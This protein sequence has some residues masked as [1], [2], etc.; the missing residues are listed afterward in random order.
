[1]YRVFLAIGGLAGMLGLVAGTVEAHVLRGRLPVERLAAFE[2][3]VRY[4]MYHALAL[5]A[6][7]WLCG[8][9]GG[10]LPVLAGGLFTVGMVFFSGSLYLRAL[11][12]QPQFGRLAPLGGSALMAG[13]LMLAISAWGRGGSEGSEAGR[14]V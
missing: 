9:G 6:V 10:R 11:T 5:L 8:R 1:M 3:G 12:D 13:W 4:Q 7:A 2:I 14:G